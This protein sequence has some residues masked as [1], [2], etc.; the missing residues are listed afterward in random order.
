MPALWVVVRGI[1]YRSR[2]SFVV[3]LLVAVTV[4]AAVAIP[5]Y[6]R[7]AQQS[8]LT[9]VLTGEQ[10]FVA[11]VTTSTSK[12]G[13]PEEALATTREALAGSVLADR[14]GE[15]HTAVRLE[16][17][18]PDQQFKTVMPMVWRGD[19]CPHVR[20]VAGN[21]PTGPG[22]MALADRTAKHLGLSV[23]QRLPLRET[24]PPHIKAAQPATPI[25]VVGLYDPA[26]T[27]LDPYWGRSY[28]F[29]MGF[30]KK[31][32]TY[33]MDTAFVAV[34]D[35]LF[36]R[37]WP[38]TVSVEH[39]LRA[40]DVRLTDVP[41]LRADLTAT[42]ARAIDADMN[43]ESGLGLALDEVDRQHQA[44]ARS[45]PLV[46]LPLLVL[47]LFVLF[48][49]AA[50]VTEERGPE[51]ALGRLRGLRPTQL[52]G[53]G[54]G[55]P[56]LLVLLA[57]PVGLALGLASTELAARTV[58][59]PGVHAEL[60]G[61]VLVAAALAL[62]GAAGSIALAARR[63]LRAGVLALLRRVPSRSR[64][65]VAAVEAA[66]GAL[67]LAALYQVLAADDRSTPIA[68]AAP[69]L[70]ALVA[71]LLA[72]RLVGWWARVRGR[73]AAARGRLTTLLSTAQLAR[74]PATARVVALLTVAVALLTFAAVGWDVAA[75]NRETAARASVPAPRVYQVTAADPR[76]LLT[77]VR[78]ADPGGTRAMAVIRRFQ[79]YN[80][81]ETVMVG[82]DTTRLAAIA[83][84]PGGDADT[85]RAVAGQLR[86]AAA[87][88]VRLRGPQ[89]SVEATVS[90]LDRAHPVSIAVILD[91]G[92]G[93]RPL[94][95]GLLAPG[96]R[97]YTGELPD[98]PDGCRLMAVAVRH[99][100][101]YS[102]PIRA[103]VTVNGI[104]DGVGQVDARLTDPTAWRT[105]PAPRPGQRLAIAAGTGL[106]ISVTS[107]PPMDAVVE[108]ADTP[109]ELPTVL[110][111][112]APSEDPEADAFEFAALGSEPDPWQVTER[113][114]ALPGAGDR[115]MLFDLETELREAVRAGLS[116]RGY[117]YQ[118]WA[119]G[120][121]DP[122]LATR[123]AEGGVQITS[124]RTLADERT[125]LG[126]LAPALALRLYLAAGTVALLLAIGTLAMTASVGARARVRELAA[127]RAVGVGRT[128]LRR[129]VR[130]EYVH[131]FGA[132]VLIGTP[133]GLAGTAL[134]LPAIPLVSI[135]PDALEP[136]YRLAGLWLPGAVALLLC[137][138]A[139]I[140]VVAPGLVRRAEPGLGAPR[141]TWSRSSAEGTR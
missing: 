89:V 29:G 118:V 63:T 51:I 79:P 104:R 126:R 137:C 69:A 107:S 23:G 135:G 38:P 31:E 80:E 97:A 56:L 121:E 82:V 15:P 18:I 117:E 4:A 2:R 125:A 130:G 5:A 110:A 9:D 134:L 90:A 128:V 58:L 131:L 20:L 47:C 61:T 50:A 26:T 12:A 37:A 100:A 127:L 36:G 35:G 123:L 43:I 105:T 115:A 60:T 84:W 119:A 55:E 72:G 27:S 99:L 141:P 103:E 101:I 64:R 109:A 88:V 129:S 138:L 91:A 76:T 86:T 59:A 53:F 22:E 78:E 39:P 19:V 98:C 116:E 95:L 40:A 45:V 8:V 81:G 133:A 13:T 111:G 120:P 30:L 94:D 10:P 139:G 3:A 41:P 42:T 46:A 44:I 17:T 34:T 106:Q 62:L 132:A 77:A 33:V 32:E 87:P 75:G 140:A 85:A 67:A 112:P 96:T 93:P 24:I 54:V 124:M 25:T 66:I 48:V 28:Y 73:R 21:C 122:G 49:V 92:D 16:T 14:L 57:T 11:G 74:R 68:Y 65:R 7:A 71:G 52:S 113:F 1:G 136:V 114:A 108:Y 70:V 83:A 102:S 6:T